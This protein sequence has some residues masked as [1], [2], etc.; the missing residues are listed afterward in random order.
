MTATTVR[1]RAPRRVRPARWAAQRS[2]EALV[3]GGATTVAL[4]HAL[5]DAFFHRQPGVGLGQHALAAGLSVVLALGAI[6]AF[7]HARPAARSAI[8]FL[9]GALATVNGMLHVKHIADLGA[10]AS[11][12]TG[13]LA[14]AAGVVLVGLAIAIPLLHRGEG[15]AGPRRRWTL[16]V[17]A[18]PVG[19]L[20]F[21]YTVVPMG[22]ALTETH[23]FRESIGPAPSQDY[24]EVAFE[25]RDG[26]EL[27]G[28]YR[29]TQ[30]GATILVVHGGGGDRTGAVDHAELLVRHGYG[31]LLYDARG[32]G[33]S[34]GTQNSWGW[35]WPED[36]AG[37]LAFL[38]ARPEVDPERIG[39]L[40]LS[41][42]ADVLV[43]VAGQGTEL[44]AVVAD[45]TAAGSFEDTQRVNGLTAITP[46]MFVEFATVRVTS[47][48]TPGPALEDMVKRI[49][50]P[51][52]LVSARGEYD[53][54]VAYDRAAGDRPVQHWHLPDASHTDAIRQAAPEYEQRVTG[55]FDQALR[56]EEK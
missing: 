18:V 40:G 4:L 16:R 49:T 9:F 51:L 11:D 3:F 45:G 32:R 53:Y 31:V 52:L 14:A 27:S 22:I 44:K 26:V 55:F 6:Y 46:F 50:S 2:W 38:K 5:D 56:K 17:L 36:V 1:E 28:W 23:K 34:E 21:V 15:T 54:G 20:A 39:A 43:Q 19:L 33:K 29:P 25:A 13:A 41:T 48:S 12:V 10:T 35:G 24:R 47:G 37:A 8:A 42:G 30:N 7:P